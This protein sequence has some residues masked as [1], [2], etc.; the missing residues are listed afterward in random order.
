MITQRD[1]RDA[2][3][4]RETAGVRLPPGHPMSISVHAFRRFV[5]PTSVETWCGIEADLVRN[6]AASPA[7]PTTGARMTTDT[8]TCLACPQASLA[9]FRS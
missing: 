1:P 3:T 4:A 9:A 8:I 2:K 6:H 5:G 7:D